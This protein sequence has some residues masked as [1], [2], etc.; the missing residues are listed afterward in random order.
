[1]TE[2][3]KKRMEIVVSLRILWRKKCC[4]FFCFETFLPG[5]VGGDGLGVVRARGLRYT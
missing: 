4:F 5:G 3:D 1:M 2:R